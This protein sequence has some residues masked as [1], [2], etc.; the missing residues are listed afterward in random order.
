LFEGPIPSDRGGDPNVMTLSEI[1]KEKRKE[2]RRIKELTSLKAIRERIEGLDPPRDFGAALDRRPLS[3]IAEFKRRSPSS[4]WINMKADPVSVAIS[5]ERAGASAISLL[6]DESFFGGNIGLLE[7]VRGRVSL[8]ILRKDFLLDPIQIYESRL[9]GADCVLLIVAALRRPLLSRMIT[10]TRKLGMSALVEVHSREELKVALDLG[11]RILGI[12]NRDLRTMRVDLRTT[13]D[14]AP[15]VPQGVRVVSESGIR[16]GRDIKLLM[17]AGVRAFLVGEEL[18][19]APDP[20]HRLRSLMEEAMGVAM[21]NGE[22]N[23]SKM[24]TTEP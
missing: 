1:L 10:L 23:H 13:L 16:S 15:L 6:T 5:Y 4:G 14:L 21:E 8:P 24:K 12:N 7:R 11:A 18:M 2:V 19:K 3:I 9:S 17:E 20:G 22:E